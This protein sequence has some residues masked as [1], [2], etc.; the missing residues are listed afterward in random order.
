[1]TATAP[2]GAADQPGRDDLTPR[3]FRALYQD[4]DLLII[5]A[6]HV[7]TPKGCQVFV[8]G[9]LGQIARQISGDEDGGPA[10]P[11]GQLP[12]RSPRS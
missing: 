7:V 8:G 2:A 11:A 6:T 4:Y 10:T 3:V 12:A 5:G 1:M 9:S